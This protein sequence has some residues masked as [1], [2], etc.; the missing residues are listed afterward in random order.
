VGVANVR[1]M[2]FLPAPP[3][4]DNELAAGLDAPGPGRSRLE[5]D[6]LPAYMQRCR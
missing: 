6:V 1:G 5:N 3:F 2:D 4:L